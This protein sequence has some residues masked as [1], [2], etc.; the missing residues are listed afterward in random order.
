MHRWTICCL[1]LVLFLSQN[2]A[3]VV[4]AV[5]AHGDPANA[6]PPST[7]KPT[8]F[9]TPICTATCFTQQRR[10]ALPALVGAAELIV[11]GHVQAIHSFWRADQRII[12]SDVTIAVA[13]K[14]LGN[15]QPTL[16]IRTVG[17]YLAAEGIGLV[18]PHAA[19]FAVG[20]E[21]LLFAYQSEGGWRTVG[22]AT[23]KFLL[24]GNTVSNADLAL[25]QAL[26]GLLPRVVELIKQRGLQTQLPTPWRHLAAAP[27]TA[28]MQPMTVQSDKRKWAPPHAGAAFYLHLN[29]AQ[30]GADDGDR[31]AF[32][33]AILTAA[34]TWSAVAGADF[35]LSYA[36]ETNATATG[37]NGVNEVLFM[38]KGSQ[39]R[40]AAA[41]VWYTAD[42]TIVEADI[43]IN[44]DYAWNATGNPAA[45]E[46]DLQSALLHE[47]G[48]WLILGHSADAN[49]VMFA[50]L[51]SG[52][53]KRELQP[54]D[55]RGIRAIYPK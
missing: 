11:R 27:A 14:L 12:E 36:G 43:W 2:P 13:Y 17:G 38:P 6:L 18:S 31:N 21:V 46:V 9:A 39:E 55:E 52:A 42:Q 20:E 49:T 48:H 23:G 47:F 19:T 26:A 51:H 22:G 8:T 54:P 30:T 16:I 4:Q 33:Q 32:R 50:R 7:A 15:P 45:N 28:T 35:T 53:L 1:L 44:E 24:A 10:D 29:T 3:P 25:R 37:Y 40:A 41:Q 34:A 5:T